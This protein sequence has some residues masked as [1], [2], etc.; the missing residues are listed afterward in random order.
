MSLIKKTNSNSELINKKKKNQDNCSSKTIEQSTLTTQSMLLK[1]GEK[2][3]EVL[4][5]NIS[6]QKHKNFI[7]T[8]V[9]KFQNRKLG[10][11]QQVLSK[12]ISPEAKLEFPIEE[13]KKYTSLCDREKIIIS[14]FSIY[15][16]LK[17][18][19][20]KESVTEKIKNIFISKNLKY[21][22]KKKVSPV[23]FELIEYLKEHNDTVGIFRA[24]S[25]PTVYRS[26]SNKIDGNIKINLSKYKEIDLACA[27]K[28]YLRDDLD[29]IFS[30]SIVDSLYLAFNSSDIELLIKI[31]KYLPF[32]IS[33]GKRNLFISTLQMYEKISLN[34]E[35][36]KMTLKNLII[37]SA[38]SFFPRIDFFDLNVCHYQALILETFI[39]EVQM[40]YVHKSIYDEAMEFSKN[41]IIQSD[42]TVTIKSSLSSCF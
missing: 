14:Y 30:A 17:Y 24:Y 40:N 3:Q 1:I 15:K 42:G 8:P 11:D 23:V 27:F 5:S 37:S 25:S 12:H 10:Y 38:P 9:F 20:G 7:L 21:F 28:S 36:N 26:I 16:I 18:I 4:K 19:C 13:Y 29:G 2:K 6:F 34:N 22:N 35:K 41:I 32:S 33:P 31:S 39:K